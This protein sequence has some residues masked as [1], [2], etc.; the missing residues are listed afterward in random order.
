MKQ[1]IEER[2]KELYPDQSG[3]IDFINMQQIVEDFRKA[4]I[5]G[6]TEALAASPDAGDWKDMDSAPKDGTPILICDDEDV[7]HKC[8][9]AAWDN[10][11][12]KGRN[13]NWCIDSSWDGEF[14]SATT[15]NKPK[16]WR[17]L[18]SPPKNDNP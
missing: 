5:A 8:L 12:N 14:D 15:V 17:A 18:P 6:A 3:T 9:W 10:S 2:A 13:K 1:T 16:K 4:Y 7:V 11:D